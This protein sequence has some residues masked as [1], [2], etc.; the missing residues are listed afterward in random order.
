MT[1]E[2]EKAAIQKA[3]KNTSEGLVYGCYMLHQNAHYAAKAFEN[4]SIS[5]AALVPLQRPM[6]VDI[7]LQPHPG[8]TITFCDGKIG[9]LD[10]RTTAT[11]RGFGSFQ[12]RL[13]NLSDAHNHMSNVHDSWK[14]FYH[15]WR[16]FLYE[17][18]KAI[19]ALV[20]ERLTA[21]YD[22]SESKNIKL[23]FGFEYL[24]PGNSLAQTAIYTVEES[25]ADDNSVKLISYLRSYA[26]TK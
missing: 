2:E 4:I 3:F 24:R 26:V 7:R 12:T 1:I 13:S 16:N 5:A 6:A 25:T 19:P 22:F 14:R 20:C 11:G 9:E 15:S 21:R 10:C 17:V 8:S 18:E 23:H